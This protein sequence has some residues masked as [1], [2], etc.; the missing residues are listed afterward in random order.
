MSKRERIYLG[1]AAG[2]TLIIAGSVLEIWLDGPWLIAAVGVLI[3][4]G[5]L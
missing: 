2:L 4:L 5:V 1:T 3:I